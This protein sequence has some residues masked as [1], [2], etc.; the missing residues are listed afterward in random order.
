MSPDS[1]S[2]LKG[3]SGLINGQGISYFSA[4][5]P[6]LYPALIAL[7]SI[8]AGD[9]LLGAR[10]L[11][12]LLLA[13]NVVLITILVNRVL[14]QKFWVGILI[15]GL[16]CLQVPMTYV[17]FYAWS[18]SCLLMC[19][20]VDVLLLSQINTTQHQFLI[21]CALIVFASFA[22]LTR[23]AG[24]IVACANC[25]MIFLLDSDRSIWRRI[26]QALYQLCIPILIF[27]PWTWHKGV[28]DGPAT[29]RIIEFHPIS[30]ETINKGIM[31][32]GRW[33]L[34]ASQHTYNQPFNFIQWAFGVAW[35]GLTIISIVW[36]LSKIYSQPMNW[37]EAAIDQFKKP[38]TI[39]IMASGILT[40]TYACF[41]IAALS[42]VDNKVEL[43][44]RILVLIYPLV[45]LMLVGL[46]F[47]IRLVKLR[48]AAVVVLMIIML[49]ALPDLKGWLLLS[50]YNGIEM[51]SRNVAMSPL[52]EYVRSCSKELQVYADHPW[53]FD[54]LFQKKVRWLPAQRLYNSGR[55]NLNYHQ[56]VLELKSKA[57]LIIIENGNSEQVVEIQSSNQF[58]RIRSDDD[59]QIFLNKS[60]QNAGCKL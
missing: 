38:G 19:I 26:R 7:F 30:V 36:V 14:N 51:T 42:F 23:F 53:N 35:I 48:N 32:L 41:L 21:R 4:Q 46:I 40:L 43:D 29:M 33:L 3:A 5:W 8:P 56:E 28:G 20:L 37:K 39:I 9:V 18:E 25:V 59:G 10:L 1:I 58:V 54:L 60:V 57:D 45:M 15:G 24:V 11:N 12:A 22:F 34:P 31:T 44:N 13:L 16:I 47:Q 2:Y 49:S 27:M 6:P 55:L 52:K 50:R 17:H